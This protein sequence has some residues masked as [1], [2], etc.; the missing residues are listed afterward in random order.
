MNAPPGA[1]L[2]RETDELAREVSGL[3][4]AI[5][6]GRWIRLILVLLTL[7]FLG[8]L[9][10]MGYQIHGDL[11]AKM[12]K[13]GEEFG[14]R[15]DK[16]IK[17][18]TAEMQTLFVNV[19]PEVQK[20][21]A[22]QAKKDSPKFAKAVAKQRDRLIKDVQ[23][24][25]QDR[26]KATFDGVVEEQKDLL[27]KEFPELQD[28]AKLD[29]VLDR[30]TQAMEQVS[31]EYYAQPIREAVDELLKR[32][33]EFPEMEDAPRDNE[34]LVDR[35]VGLVFEM[36]RAVIVEPPTEMAATDDAGVASP[37]GAQVAAEAEQAA[38]ITEQREAERAAAE[39]AAEEKTAAEKAATDEEAAGA[40]GD[41]EG[42]GA[43]TGGEAPVEEQPA[44]GSGD[45]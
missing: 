35:I 45:S 17:P 11:Q 30:M 27:V 25:L 29:K 31:R 28:K 20:A 13:V 41:A 33:D 24:K 40:G 19:R 6:A 39:K 9:T 22:A 44:A 23:A 10:W 32:L 4:A 42:G 26:L 38:K 7:A 34:E 12:D 14:A 3:K 8:G 2:Q 18:A 5:A 37:Q 43:G 16:F 36:G 21:F 1:T 15:Q